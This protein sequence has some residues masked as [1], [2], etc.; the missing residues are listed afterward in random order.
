MHSMHSTGCG[1]GPIRREAARQAGKGSLTV[2]V[3]HHLRVGA[4]DCQRPHPLAAELRR[5]E[6]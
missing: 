6:G 4:Y 2:A 5:V 3:R 1:G